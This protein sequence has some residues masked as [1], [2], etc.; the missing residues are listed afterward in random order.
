MLLNGKHG[1]KRVR[2]KVKRMMCERCEEEE[3]NFISELGEVLCDECTA[4]EFAEYD[5]EYQVDHYA[6]AMILD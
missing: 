3:G 4:E 6:L 1:L 2:K 5:T